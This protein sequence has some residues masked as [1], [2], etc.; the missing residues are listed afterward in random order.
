[1]DLAFFATLQVEMIFNWFYCHGES[2]ET[3]T[4]KMSQLMTVSIL[5]SFREEVAPLDSP[6]KNTFTKAQLLVYRKKLWKYRKN[7]FFTLVLV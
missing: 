4:K 5:V 3:M 6:Q 2:N 1:M 7:K